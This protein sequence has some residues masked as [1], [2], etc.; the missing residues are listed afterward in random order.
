MISKVLLICAV[1]LPFAIVNS[2][3]LSE[4]QLSKATQEII[5][6]LQSNGGADTVKKYADTVALIY[7]ISNSA[8]DDERIYNSAFKK[9]TKKHLYKH[10]VTSGVVISQDG[11][12]CTTSKSIMNSDKIIV[13]INSELRAPADNSKITLDK[14]SYVASVI[15][16]I[17]EL[18][19]AFLRIT[20]QKGKSL[21][22]IPL[23]ND[24]ELIK[25]KLLFNSS[26]IIGKARGE[27]FVTELTP[28]NTKNNF[29]LIASGIEKL[30]Y[31]KIKGTPTLLVDNAITYT[32]SFPEQEGGAIVN[33]SGELMGI[34]YYDND[35]EHRGPKGIPVSVIKQAIKIAVPQMVSAPD[36]YNV[37]INASMRKYKFPSSL[38]KTLKISKDKDTAVCVDS[39]DVDSPADKSG[40]KPQDIIIMINNELVH[41]TETYKNLEKASW[42][43]QTITLKILRDDKL[44]DI[45]IVR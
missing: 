20:L 7:T 35:F 33:T 19:L 29:A 40:I 22:Y 15:K 34:A 1:G 24:A 28:A 4:D 27:H 13:S 23:G 26:V 44:M 9:R 45:E 16:D 42:G 14:D 11:V 10:G 18:N 37:G 38:Q 12:I 36:N 41:D 5:D 32:G 39:I 8:K 31:K 21:H 2:Q 3:T 6:Q 43:N 30:S 25:G 17:P